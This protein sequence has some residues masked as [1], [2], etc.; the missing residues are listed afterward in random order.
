[1]V[2]ILIYGLYYKL[3]F[4]IC[5]DING[6]FRYIEISMVELQLVVWTLINDCYVSGN[7]RYHKNIST[8]WFKTLIGNMNIHKWV[9]IYLDPN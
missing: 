2:W 4:V 3:M 5:S 9:A 8:P 1:M 7:L 6:N